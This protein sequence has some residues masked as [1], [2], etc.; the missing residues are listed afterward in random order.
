MNLVAIAMGSLQAVREAGMWIAETDAEFDPTK[1][2]PGVMGFVMTGIFAGAVILLGFLLV[3]RLRRNAYRHE[4]RE[5]I[6]QELAERA[7]NEAGAQGQ[8][9]QPDGDAPEPEKPNQA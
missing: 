3:K 7:A 5:G 8:S 2:S 9:T 1:V 6:E 4:I